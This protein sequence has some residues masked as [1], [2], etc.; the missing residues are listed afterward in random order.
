VKER[1]KQEKKK[2]L[3]G[4]QISTVITVVTETSWDRREKSLPALLALW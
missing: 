4:L 2:V 1:K 3:D